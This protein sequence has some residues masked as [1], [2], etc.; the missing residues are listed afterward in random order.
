M[1]TAA[2]D[3]KTMAADRQSTT[4]GMR[5][6]SP[7]AKIHQGTYHGMPALFAGA[8]T[9]VYS[10]SMIEWLLLGMPDERKPEMPESPDSFTVFVATE[11]GVF[12]YVDSLRPIPLGQIKW[13]IG[14]GGE[15]AFGA[16]DAGA[17][18]KRAVEIACDR[19]TNSG[20][21]VDVLTLRKSK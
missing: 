21:G 3:G 11:A 10:A 2:W 8:G 15:Y 17:S 6:Q 19:D 20:M 9:V 14:S 4:G 7:Q 16:M 5:H 18:A 12:L 13:A 1:T